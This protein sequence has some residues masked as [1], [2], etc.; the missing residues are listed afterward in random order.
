MD[1]LEAEIRLIKERNQRVE[2]DK[3]WETSWFRRGLIA[4]ITYAVASLALYV[5]GVTDF[6]L[7][8]FIPTLGFLL[9]TLTLPAVKRW[10]VT[11]VYRAS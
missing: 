2:S 3:A 1:T 8:A 10:W 9:S 4:V 5:I 7:A 6:Y 11:R